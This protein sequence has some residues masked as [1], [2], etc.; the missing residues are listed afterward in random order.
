MNINWEISRKEE[1]GVFVSIVFLHIKGLG[2]AISLSTKST[3][4]DNPIT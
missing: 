4:R 2:Y 1:K 3:T